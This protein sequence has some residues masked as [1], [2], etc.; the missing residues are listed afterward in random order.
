MFVLG[1]TGGIGCGKSTV[2]G[3]CQEAGLPVIDAGVLSHQ[4][5]AAGGS[6]LP[7]LVEL[8]GSGIMDEEGALNREKMARLVF[9]DKRSLD[10]LSEVV[11]KHAI[12]SMR[13]QVETLRESKQRAV[14]LDVP[15]PVK[16]GFLDLCDQVWVAWSSDEVRLD[17]L[18]CRGMEAEEVQRRMAMQMSRA[19]YFKIADHII[20][21][22]G[23]LQELKRATE[24]LLIQELKERGVK[25]KPFDW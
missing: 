14:V 16:D 2:A 3:F 23:T 13:E 18:K 1:I 25:I 19:T 21:N 22:D 20:E 7:E 9:R 17:R 24:E 11:H 4:V 8:F 10:L 6:A 15:I 12:R 5:T